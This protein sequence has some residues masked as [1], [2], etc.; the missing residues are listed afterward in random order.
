MSTVL[1]TWSSQ[2]AVS[3]SEY[4]IIPLTKRWRYLSIVAP[5]DGIHKV[6]RSTRLQSW[7]DEFC[8]TS[9][10]DVDY[11]AIFDSGILPPANFL[12]KTVPCLMHDPKVAFNLSE[13]GGRYRASVFLLFNGTGDVWRWSAIEDVEGWHTDQWRR[14]WICHFDPMHVIGVRSFSEMLD[15]WASCHQ[16]C[17]HI[18]HN[19]ID[20]AIFEC[21]LLVNCCRS[22]FNPRS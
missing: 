5:N 3:L 20:G 7:I 19:S 14:S 6:S 22:S 21:K 11:I 17:L 2:R 12:F 16:L 1:V 13:Q 15:A 8:M 9:I 10:K 4:L 18:S